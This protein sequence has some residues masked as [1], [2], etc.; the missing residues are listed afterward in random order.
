MENI[1]RIT[2]FAEQNNIECDINAFEVIEAI[3][4]AKIETEIYKSD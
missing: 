1:D 2:Q 3:E 4:A